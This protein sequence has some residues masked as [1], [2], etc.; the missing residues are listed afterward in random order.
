MTHT[1]AIEKLIEA[2][3]LIYEVRSKLTRAG[4]QDID[5][6]LFEASYDK[7]DTAI[8]KLEGK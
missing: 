4:M 1:Q 6:L 2:N 5:N 7:I 3:D 8:E